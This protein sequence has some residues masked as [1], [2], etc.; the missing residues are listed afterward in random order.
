ML[1]KRPHPFPR[2][3]T[4]SNVT[5]SENSPRSTVPSETMK[6]KLARIA[7]KSVIENTIALSNV[8][9]PLTSSVAFVAMLVI[10][11]VI[12]PTDSVA[13]TLATIPMDTDA[14]RVALAVVMLSTGRWSSCSRNL[15]AIP[16]GH[17]Q[18]TSKRDQAHMIKAIPM[19]AAPVAARHDLGSEAQVVLQPHGVGVEMRV[20]TATVVH[21]RL[22]PGRNETT[23]TAAKVEALQVR[24][25]GINNL[26]PHRHHQ[27]SMAQDIPVRAVMATKAIILDSKA[28]WLPP[29]CLRCTN[30]MVHLHHLLVLLLPLHHLAMHLLHHLATLLHRHLL[31][32]E[33]HLYAQ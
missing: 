10:W 3:K 14:R 17:Q 18:A 21:L 5:S 7:A 26:P 20:K 33:R 31:Q 6:I 23:T 1:L 30:S 29:V 9:S 16:A 4:S 2:V 24:R 13:Q 25:H 32:L 22:R 15:A 28:W 11:L 19:V 27:V 12:V 8:I